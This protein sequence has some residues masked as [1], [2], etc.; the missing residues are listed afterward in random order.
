MAYYSLVDKLTAA[1]FSFYSLPTV[2]LARKNDCQRALRVWKSACSTRWYLQWWFKGNRQPLL[3]S[4]CSDPAP[5]LAAQFLLLKS[6]SELDA[7][8]DSNPT[9][10]EAIIELNV[11]GIRPGS[12]FDRNGRRIVRRAK[13][14]KHENPTSFRF[15]SRYDGCCMVKD[16]V[17]HGKKRKASKMQ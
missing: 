2:L 4:V 1:I 11:W 13:E 15:S 7:E 8:R 5:P 6:M 14:S 3:Q 12:P 16:K 9:S 10:E 17:R